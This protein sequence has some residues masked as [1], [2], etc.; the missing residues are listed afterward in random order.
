MKSGWDDPRDLEFWSCPHCSNREVRGSKAIQDA[1]NWLPKPIRDFDPA[2][3][4]FEHAI[5]CEYWQRHT[6]GGKAELLGHLGQ[7]NSHQSFNMKMQVCRH[8]WSNE[9]MTNCTELKEER[10]EEGR[11]GGKEGGREGRNG[12]NGRSG[13]NGW[14]EWN[15]MKWT[16]IKWSYSKWNEMEWMVRM[17]ERTCT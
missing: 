10:M 16:E 7:Y 2:S 12:R 13:S 14:N 15:E 11:E 5:P 8:E 3:F 1:M 17:D 4:P 9:W 6:P